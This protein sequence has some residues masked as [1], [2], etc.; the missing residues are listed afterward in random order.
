[1][2]QIAPS[3]LSAD[4]AHLADDCLKLYSPDNPILHFD[5]MDGL[6]VPNITFG[7]PVLA[8]LKK[9]IPKAVYDVHLMIQSPQ[10]YLEAFAKAGA[11]WLTFH[12]EA[13][14]DAALLAEHIHALGCKAGVSVRPGTAIETVFPLLSK[15][16][17]VLVMSVEPGF[18]GQSFQPQATARIAALRQEAQRQ[19]QELMI[20]VDGGINAKT[21][22][23]CRKAGA[24]ILVAGSLIFNAENPKKALEML[25]EI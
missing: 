25:K 18:G 10:N 22:R 20:E 14:G 16:D 13:E 19:K 11:D 9:A 23:L 8:S 2:T 4:L 17:M 6:F 7:I 3:I 5:V 15:V 21:G 24:D 12:L 1:M